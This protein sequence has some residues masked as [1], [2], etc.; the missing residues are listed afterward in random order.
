MK[1]K[2]GDLKQPTCQDVILWL[3]SMGIN[4]ERNDYEVIS[5]LQNLK[6]STEDDHISDDLPAV[7]LDSFHG[8]KAEGDS[9]ADTAIEELRMYELYRRRFF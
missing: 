6:H 2:W 7:D 5:C 4:Q 9:D 8:S 3:S 1:T